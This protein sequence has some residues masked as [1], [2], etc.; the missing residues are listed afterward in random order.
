MVKC[1]YCKKLF[2]NQKGLNAHLCIKHKEILL[3]KPVVINSDYLD[4]TYRQ[5]NAKRL[6]HSNRCDVCGKV[7]TT[8]TRPESKSYP[9][10]LCTDHDHNTNKFRGFLC[11]QCNRNFGWYDK[12]KEQIIKHSNFENA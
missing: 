3:D 4:I 6:K 10:Q 8:N 5:L 7:E 2:N 9:N 12:Y 11:V 1:T